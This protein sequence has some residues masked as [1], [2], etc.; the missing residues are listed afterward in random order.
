MWFPS[1]LIHRS[2][3]GI[4]EPVI[5]RIKEI[6]IHLVFGIHGNSGGDLTAMSL[7][8]F[9]ESLLRHLQQSPAGKVLVLMEFANHT[10]LESDELVSLIKSGIKPSEAIVTILD[11]YYKSRLSAAS[12]QSSKETGFAGVFER[13]YRQILDEAYEQDQNRI[14]ILPEWA[15]EEEISSSFPLGNT[16]TIRLFQLRAQQKYP[17]AFEVF[18]ELVTHQALSAQT[19]ENRLADLTE[20]KL[21]EDPEIVAVTGFFGQCHTG[22]F[23]RLKKDGL[24]VIRTL[25]LESNTRFD[26]GQLESV[27]RYRRFF[28]EREFTDNDWR[29]AFRLTTGVDMN[30]IC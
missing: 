8:S 14:E 26:F 28:P 12:Y 13:E 7:Q 11:P 27:I 20:Q 1:K 3:C 22:L 24:S 16:L 5:D 15:P 23:I 4:I 10:R 21:N 30:S 9:R 2:Y 6:P 18:Q 19:R 25:L 17:E 29:E